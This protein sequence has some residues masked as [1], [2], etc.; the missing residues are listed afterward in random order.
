MFSAG[1]NV[2][3]KGK[4]RQSSTS[5]NGRADRAIDGKTDGSFGS[6]TQTHT[7]EGDET[8]WWEVDLG[9]EQPIDSIT[10]WNRRENELGKRLNGFTLLLLDGSR[11]EV[12]SKTGQPAPEANVSFK[13]SKDTE[14]ELRRGD[15]RC[16]EHEP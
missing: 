8:P 10:I 15:S 6:G 1:E 4:A 13:I 9:S 7:R 3:R 12:F 16:G 2:A 11:H 14:S 5:N